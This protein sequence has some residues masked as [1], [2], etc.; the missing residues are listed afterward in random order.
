[1]KDKYDRVILLTGL[2]YPIK[3]RSALIKIFTDNKDVNYIFASGG[4]V[5]SNELTRLKYR[6]YYDNIFIRLIFH[7]FRKYFPGSFIVRKIGRASCRE[8]V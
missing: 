2:D 4:K 8:R 5:D 7:F 6:Y 3:S 1:M